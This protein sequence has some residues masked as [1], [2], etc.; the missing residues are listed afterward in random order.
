MTQKSSVL[1]NPIVKGLTPEEHIQRLQFALASTNLGIWDWDLRD[2]AV[3][4]DRRWCEMLG[5][6]QD[7][8]PMHL[9]TWETRVHP[10]DLP[11]CYE[12]INAYLQGQTPIYR[13][14]HRMRHANGDWIYILDCGSISG[15]DADGRPIRFTGTHTDI[16]QEERARRLLA[17]RSELY[18]RMIRFLP[19]AVVMLDKNLHYIVASER[20][21]QSQ[22]LSESQLRELPPTACFPHSGRDWH[23]VARRVLDGETLQQD[24]E[25]AKQADGRQRWCRWVCLPWT[26][27]EGEIGGLIFMIEDLTESIYLQQRMETESRLRSLGK[28]AGGIA[29]EVN[30]PLAIIRAHAE[31]VLLKQAQKTLTADFLHQSMDGVIHTTR[32]IE[33]IIRALRTISHGSIKTQLT[34]CRLESIVNETVELCRERFAEKNIR[35]TIDLSGLSAPDIRVDVAQISQIIFN[36]INNAYDAVHDLPE[37]WVHLAAIE[38]PNLVRLVLQDSG[39]GIAPDVVD[40]MMTPFFTTKEVGTGMGLGLSLSRTY[41]KNHGGE[42][43]YQEINGH[44]AFVLTLPTNPSLS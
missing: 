39:R 35:L 25:L 32:R 30:N 33:G 31:I 43:F 6:D 26:L 36:L 5:L 14:V 29:H 2:D 21:L 24:R 15:R 44:T 11:R 37:R 22:N 23:E 9:S 7:V 28:M 13:N 18:D 19:S 12:D 38:E 4:F 20:W 1:P 40:R 3:H 41:A 27:E 34:Q 8:T 17:H 10:D 42:L 16:T